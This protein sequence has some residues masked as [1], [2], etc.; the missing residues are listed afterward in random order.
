M[1][2]NGYV[3]DAVKEGRWLHLRC[4]RRRAGMKSSRPCGWDGY[5]QA[6]ALLAAFGQ[7]ADSAMLKERLRCPGCGGVRKVRHFACNPL[8]FDSG[9]DPIFELTG[10]FLDVGIRLQNR[11]SSVQVLLPL[12]GTKSSTWRPPGGRSGRRQGRLGQARQSAAC[13]RREKPRI[14]DTGCGS[15]LQRSVAMTCRGALLRSLHGNFRFHGV[16]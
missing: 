5:L 9:V 16:L 1:D 11:G 8:I 14:P 12:P 15:P 3:M 6:E 4:Q 2:A 10:C 13:G 7:F